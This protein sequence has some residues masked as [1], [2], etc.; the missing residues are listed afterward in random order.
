MSCLTIR[1]SFGLTRYEMELYFGY[2]Y[3]SMLSMV[4]RL[5]ID[6]MISEVKN[7]TES[8]PQ[9]ILDER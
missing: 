4:E 1:R 6:K 2:T 3:D 9:G 8:E 7:E 5:E